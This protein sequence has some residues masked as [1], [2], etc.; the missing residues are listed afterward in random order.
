[1]CINMKSLWI[2]NKQALREIIWPNNNINRI[3]MIMASQ[4]FKLNKLANRLAKR[5]V[6]TTFQ[7]NSFLCDVIVI[8]FKLFFELIAY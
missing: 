4:N 2:N 5:N 3:S 6:S 1:M 8:I 7:K